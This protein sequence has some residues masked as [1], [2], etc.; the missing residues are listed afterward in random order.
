MK[1]AGQDSLMTNAELGKCLATHARDC[2]DALAAIAKG[3]K[4]AQ[5][6]DVGKNS[7]PLAAILASDTSAFENRLAITM[8]GTGSEF[9]MGPNAGG[10][11]FKGTGTGE[12]GTGGYGRIHGLGSIDTGNNRGITANMGKKKTEAAPKVD[13]VDQQK[14]YV[15]CVE[16]IDVNTRSR[17]LFTRALEK[18]NTLLNVKQ[19]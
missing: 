19:P 6:K 9:L 5:L 12:G 8:S 10:K 13:G 18:C 14:A 16:K 3:E 2:K 17:N 11:G 15:A 7:T 1:R 4:K